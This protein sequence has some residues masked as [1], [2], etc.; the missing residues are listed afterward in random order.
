[1]RTTSACTFDESLPSEPEAYTSPPDVSLPGY[2]SPTAAAQLHQHYSLLHFLHIRSPPPSPPPSSSRRQQRKSS[3]SVAAET[4][5]RPQL[6]IQVLPTD[7]TNVSFIT[8]MGKSIRQPK[9]MRMSTRVLQSLGQKRAGNVDVEVAEWARVGGGGSVEAA[10]VTCVR[11]IR[12]CRVREEGA[13]V[14]RVGRVVDRPSGL[15][16]LLVEEEVATVASVGRA[17]ED[18]G[19]AA[20]AVR[21][22][23]SVLELVWF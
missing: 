16:A 5:V 11:A 8:M 18:G 1:M 21:L 6:I 22:D 10:G 13:V 19:F 9:L 4:V 3:E 23:A 20:R 2:V 17:G 15:R 14:E 12:V 7:A